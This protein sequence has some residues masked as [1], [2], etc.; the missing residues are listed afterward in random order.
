MCI[1]GSGLCMEGEQRKNQSP[2]RRAGSC[3]WVRDSDPDWSQ[4]RDQG[5]GGVTDIERVWS[6]SI[7]W[8]DHVSNRDINS[9][10]AVRE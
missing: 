6:Q 5:A 1:G 7:M 3:V 10:S 2:A 8:L 4:R 9:P